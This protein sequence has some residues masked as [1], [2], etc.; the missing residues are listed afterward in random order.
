MKVGAFLDILEKI[1][2]QYASSNK[3]RRRIAD[4]ILENPAKCCFYSLKEFAS[5]ASTTQVTVLNFCRDLEIGSF[6]DLK[7]SLQGHMLTWIS[8]EERKKLAVSQSTSQKELLTQVVE[9]DLRAIQLTM[10]ENSLEDIL[11]FVDLL[12]RAKHVYLAAHNAS[13]PPAY[14][15]I[16]RMAWAGKEVTMLDME[17]HHRIFLMLSSHS[18]EDTLLTAISFSPYSPC[19][20]AA[21]GFC[22]SV[23]IPVVS[24][25]DLLTSPLTESS[26]VSLL[27]NMTQMGFTSSAAAMLSLINVLSMLYAYEDS[28]QSS[29]TREEL[30]E[31]SRRFDDFF[32]DSF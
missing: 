21:A 10:E 32:S 16:R 24:I 14:Y 29:G 27:C 28:Q 13:R 8:P 6:V 15:F 12:Y 31:M 5:A 7:K 2:A 22:Q 3:V 30:P 4:L 26:C 1:K 18:R 11:K 20:L 25:T 19:T 23:G 17:D 9:A